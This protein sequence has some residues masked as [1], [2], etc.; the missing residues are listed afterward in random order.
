[1]STALAGTAT[2][3][4]RTQEAQQKAAEAAATQL[5]SLEQ[6]SKQHDDLL[7]RYDDAL[8]HAREL[9]TQLDDRLGGTLD[10]IIDRVQQYNAGVE[11]N[12]RVIMEQVNGTMPAMGNLLHTATEE[13][14][15]QIEE[16]SDTLQEL[17]TVVRKRGSDGDNAEESGSSSGSTGPRR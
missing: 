13:L 6:M 3:V 14:K 2:K 15:E 10:L 17:R 7:G 9:F 8:G 11:Q 4:T 5:V 1:L 16:L 12:F